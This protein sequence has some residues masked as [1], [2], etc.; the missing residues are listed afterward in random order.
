[1]DRH[2]RLCG[3]SSAQLLP[4]TVER[5]RKRATRPD[6]TAW[7]GTGETDRLAHGQD[8][9]GGRARL[10][11]AVWLPGDSAPMLAPLTVLLVVQVTLHE[12]VTGGLQRVGS[13]VAAGVL[14][15]AF[16]SEV[17]G[18]TWWGPGW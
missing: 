18:L 13:V 17:V 4:R 5:V 16:V 14:L 15:A 2:L 10:V 7:R 1:M 11:I 8:H 6:W 3:R 9:P 12:T